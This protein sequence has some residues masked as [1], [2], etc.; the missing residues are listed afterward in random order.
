MEP[1]GLPHIP[2]RGARPPRG[3]PAGVAEQGFLARL[4][5]E[6]IAE[7]KQENPDRQ[8]DFVVHALPA[9]LADPVLLKQV[10][11]NLLGNAVKFCGAR[12]NA[13]I[14]IGSTVGSDADLPGAVTYFVKDN[15][16]GFD[17]RYVDKLFGVFQ[18]L[19]SL[20][21]YPGTGV[22]LAIVQRIIIRHAGAVTAQGERGKGATFGFTLPTEV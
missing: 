6:V 20:D 21:D 15:G 19:H 16:V 1:A 2:S 7:L 14:E 13:R 11:R 5:Y 3:L 12:P 8:I 22:G 10:F 9:C 4:S 18:R 17:M